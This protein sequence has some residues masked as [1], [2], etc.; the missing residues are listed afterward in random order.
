[1][2]RVAG[3]AASLLLVGCAVDQPTPPPMVEPGGEFARPSGE[4]RNPRLG[5]VGHNPTASGPQLLLLSR[6]AGEL[7]LKKDELVVS[8]SRDLKPTALLKIVDIRGLAALA[9]VVRG[10]PGANEEIVLPSSLLRQQA[11]ALPPPPPG[12]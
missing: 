6:T 8:R 10:Q 1:V 7:S 5:F 3:I 9:V 2:S 4:S 12:S 11:E